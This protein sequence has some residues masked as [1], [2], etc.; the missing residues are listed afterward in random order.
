MDSVFGDAG[1]GDDS[2]EVD[3]IAVKFLREFGEGVAD[4]AE[5]CCALVR[6]GFG[7][8]EGGLVDIRWADEEYGKRSAVGGSGALDHFA[9]VADGFRHAF[10]RDVAGVIRAEREHQ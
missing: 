9:H 4:V 10:R 7:G 3:E 8:D 6:D 5:F 1:F 2:E